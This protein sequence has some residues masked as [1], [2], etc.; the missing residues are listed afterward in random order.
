MIR[1]VRPALEHRIAKNSFEFL[2]CPSGVVIH[3]IL[4]KDAEQ[5]ESPSGNA[6]PFPVTWQGARQLTHVKHVPHIKKATSSKIKLPL[7]LCEYGKT[8]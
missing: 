3:P 1:E 8:L 5:D 2:L 4:N 7:M 6:L